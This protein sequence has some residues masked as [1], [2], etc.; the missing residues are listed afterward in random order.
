MMFDLALVPMG[1]LM[2]SVL[3]PMMAGMVILSFLPESA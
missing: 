2:L 1:T 3:L